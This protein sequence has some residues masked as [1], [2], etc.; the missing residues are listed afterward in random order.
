MRLGNKCLHA[1]EDDEDD[2]GTLDERWKQT[3]DC[4]S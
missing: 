3:C 4:S 1:V 2:A